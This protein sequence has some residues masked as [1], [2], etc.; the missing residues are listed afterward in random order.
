MLGTIALSLAGAVEPKAAYDQLPDK[1]GL[2]FE[3][4]DVDTADGARLH[5]W[6][7]PNTNKK[8]RTIVFVPDGTGNMGDDLARVQALATLGYHVVTFDYRGFG[9]SSAFEMDPKMHLYP[10]F[11]DDV[12]AAIGWATRKAGGPVDLLGWGIGAGLGLGIGWGRADVARIV[13]DGPFL[14]IEA[15]E[16]TFSSWDPQPEVPFAG[17]EKKHEPIFSLDG[18]PGIAPKLEKRVLLITGSD[19][20]ICRP[21]DLEALRAK[22]PNVVGGVVVV[23][24]PE[25]KEN[26]QA[27]PAA[28]T[29]AVGT[30]LKK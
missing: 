22:Q 15:L 18:A 27:D 2:T 1:V 13:A 7:I 14:S 23:P 26:F 10:H 21:A 3:A 30:F 16:K 11:Q 9:A 6:W 12:A 8:A 17:Y 20:R 19:D 29:A 4:F 25:R 24:N 5:G 28:Y